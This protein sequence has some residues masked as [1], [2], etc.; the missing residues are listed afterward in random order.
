MLRKSHL[1]KQ[2]WKYKR[3]IALGTG[4]GVAYYTGVQS[5]V[6]KGKKYNVVNNYSS[7]TLHLT[8]PK[9]RRGRYGKRKR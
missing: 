8:Q 6:Q 3:G 7:N 4:L 5:G 2:L 1:A 9:K